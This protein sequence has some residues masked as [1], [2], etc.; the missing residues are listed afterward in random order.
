MS[1]TEKEETKNRKEY[2]KEKVRQLALDEKIANDE[3]VGKGFVSN[4]RYVQK[5]VRKTPYIDNMALEQQ[6][7]ETRNLYHQKMNSALKSQKSD[8]AFDELFNALDL[9]DTSNLWDRKAALAKGI[10]DNKNEVMQTLMITTSDFAGS[11]GMVISIVLTLFLT[12]SAAFSN[13]LFYAF[14]G[15]FFFGMYE[16]IFNQS[17]LKR[18]IKEYKDYT[19]EFDKITDLLKRK[20]EL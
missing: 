2:A 16:G 5:V 17:R 9:N 13:Y 14:F 4:V 8:G 15:I 6:Y 19:S 10:N 7:D 3:L 18:L 11:V 20:K 12:G 1:T